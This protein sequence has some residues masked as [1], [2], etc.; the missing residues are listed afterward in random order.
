MSAVDV[1]KL[2]KD[3]LNI[4]KKYDLYHIEV[5]GVNIWQ[6]FRIDIW[7]EI[8][9]QKSG[10][11]GDTTRDKHGETNIGKSG[12]IKIFLKKI[13]YI[14]TH[15]NSKRI[16]AADVLF[17]NF[18][19]KFLR[20]GVYIDKLTG[21][22]ETCFHDNFVIIEFSRNYAMSLRP[23]QS[24]NEY[25]PE[26]LGFIALLRTKI[27]TFFNVNEYKNARNE[28]EKHFTAPLEEFKRTYD[29]Q[30]DL[31]SY[32]H[33][34]AMQILKIK[35]LKK[36]YR[37]LLN[38]I[39]PKVIL[40]TLPNSRPFM[41]IN[42]IAKEMNIPTI[43]LQ[44]AFPITNLI[45]IYAKDCGEIRQ[46]PDYE[47]G[48]SD[49]F[50]SFM[51]LPIP[52]ENI[53]A[54]GLPYLEQCLSAYPKCKKDNRVTILFISQ[55]PH[56]KQLSKLAVEIREHL[57]I[58][59]YRIIYK[60]HPDETLVWK[61]RLPWL[62]ER[63]DIEVIDNR[64][65]ETYRCFAESD[66]QIGVNSTALFEGMAYNL[67]TYIFKA[68]YWEVMSD[69]IKLGYATLITNCDDFLSNL[70]HTTNAKK[71]LKEFLWQGNALENML[72]EIELISGV[73]GNIELGKE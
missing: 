45:W 16:H 13:G 43:E 53:K 11:Q 52:A 61:E 3:Y 15:K 24:Q 64:T 65:Y 19:R 54:V 28:V 42:E 66:I 5:N 58:D 72:R 30:I 4:E 23:T 25:Y 49:Y 1:S 55:G 69:V 21:Q 68:T 7:Y 56:A 27:E 63:K 20:N 67:E 73:K 36:S 34:M 33:D 17:L 35:R 60:L 22:L 41:I 71:P 6:Y 44:H 62:R 40:E 9:L 57:D 51:N 47:F 32:F 31:Q 38:K 8:L 29:W 18:G 46:F 39:H 48:Y 37:R 26:L 70:N 14:L 10:T 50:N 2:Q 12:E 59:Q